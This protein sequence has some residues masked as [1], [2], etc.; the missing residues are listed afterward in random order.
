MKKKITARISSVLAAAAMT[1]STQTV[2]CAAA[3]NKT[4]EEMQTACDKLYAHSREFRVDNEVFNE[5]YAKVKEKID[6]NPPAYD[7]AQDVPYDGPKVNYADYQVIRDKINELYSNNGFKDLSFAVTNDTSKYDIDGDGR[8]S[9]YDYCYILRY[10]QEDLGL[11]DKYTDLSGPDEKGVVSNDMLSME[12]GEGWL[13]IKK[14]VSEKTVITLPSEVCCKVETEIVENGGKKKVASWCILPVASIETN[15]F[16]ACK[17]MVKLNIINYIQP[18]WFKQVGKYEGEL[19]NGNLQPIATGGKLADSCFINISDGAFDGCKNLAII[20]FGENINFSRYAFNGTRFGELSKNVWEDEET[21]IWYVR[22]SDGKAKVACA[23]DKNKSLIYRNGIYNL[24][25]ADG[26][27]SIASNIRD[28]FIDVDENAKISVNLP[29]NIKYIHKDAFSSGEIWD[30]DYNVWDWTNADCSGINWINGKTFN[31]IKNEDA[32]FAKYLEDNNGSFKCTKFMAAPVQNIINNKVTEI[33]NKYGYDN[34]NDKE[35]IEEVCSYI[36]NKADYTSFVGS[37]DEFSLFP[38]G[39]Y[40]TLDQPRANICAATN[41]FLTDQTECESY[42]LAVS[43]LLDKLDINNYLLGCDGHAYN[44]VFINNKWQVIDMSCYGDY[45]CSDEL[46]SQSG[47]TSFIRNKMRINSSNGNYEMYVNEPLAI[48]PKRVDGVEKETWY[49]MVTIGGK[50]Q[51]AAFDTNKLIG[52][53]VAFNILGVSED[54]S[55]LTIAMPTDNIPASIKE[56]I[57]NGRIRI[58]EYNGVILINGE[59]Y[60]YENNEMVTDSTRR[61]GNQTVYFDKTGKMK[62]TGWVNTGEKSYYFKNEYELAC[63]ETLNLERNGSENW[64]RFNS[65]CSMHIGLGI[66]DYSLCYFDINGMVKNSSRYENG[67][68][69]FFDGDGKYTGTGWEEIEGTT[70]YFTGNGEYAHNGDLDIT[71]NGKTYTYRFDQYGNRCTNWIEDGGVYYLYDKD[72]HKVKKAFVEW[73]HLYFYLDKNGVMATN[74]YVHWKNGWVLRA[75]SFGSLDVSVFG[76]NELE[77]FKSE[78]VAY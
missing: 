78:L 67:K 6:E 40:N 76:K 49:P 29:E 10:A 66:K 11:T 4:A 46:Y 35:K 53:D 70:Y 42:A 34:N 2:F 61:I 24:D 36:F 57:D 16:S 55:C 68:T 77:E 17:N 65:D 43:L 63:N 12:I 59:L 18:K 30:Y 33:N 71:E 73:E 20:N 13:S 28:A 58:F 52:S 62:H 69:Y 64:F 23:A 48:F 5:Q 60:Y 27:T 21:G 38:N 9:Y 22:S 41:G 51:Y 15:A 26:T 37:R 14:L 31:E 39:V 8:I 56:N 3:A 7:F 47:N 25:I 75:D 74:K 19:Y 54:Q 44:C 1:L 45:D 32:E 72:Y 50:K